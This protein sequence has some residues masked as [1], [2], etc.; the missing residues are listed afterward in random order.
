[1]L[2]LDA[3]VLRAAPRSVSV[4][5]STSVSF[6]CEWDSNPP[7]S[8]TWYRKQ[9]EMKIELGSGNTLEVKSAQQSDAGEILCVAKAHTVAFSIF[10]VNFV[11]LIDNIFRSGRRKPQQ[12]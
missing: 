9:G 7:A 10:I 12:S 8:V 6:T 11:C 1:M 5:E 2:S 3:P 4:N